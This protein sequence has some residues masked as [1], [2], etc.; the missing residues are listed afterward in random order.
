MVYP[1][2]ICAYTKPVTIENLPY[3]EILINCQ[4]F[5]VIT[6]N[7]CRRIIPYYSHRENKATEK[8]RDDMKVLG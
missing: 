5:N 3:D 8:A 7:K 6:V 1:S 2:P 4:V